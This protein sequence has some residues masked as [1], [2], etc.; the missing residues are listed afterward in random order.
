NSTI[1]DLYR[2]YTDFW[3]EKVARNTPRLDEPRSRKLIQ[4][5]A[6]KMFEKNCWP[7]TDDVDNANRTT[8]LPKIHYSGL[9]SLMP[10]SSEQ[11]HEDATRNVNTTDL[12][13]LAKDLVDAEAQISAS[14]EE[15]VLTKSFLVRDDF[16]NYFFAH[17]SFLEYFVA[18]QLFSDMKEG[19]KEGF[20]KCFLSPEI[21]DF[22]VCLK[23]NPTT[24]LSWIAESRGE[25]SHLHTNLLT[26]LNKTGNNLRGQNFSRLYL[27]GADLGGAD[28][29]NC[30]FTASTL[31]K[32]D[33]RDCRLTNTDF[34]DASFRNL[35][36]GV[37][38][39]A[40]GVAF[41]PNGKF[42][43]SGGGNNAVILL[44]KDREKWLS[45]E[46]LGH[47]DSITNVAFSSDNRFLASS[48]FDQ[49]AIVWKLNGEKHCRLPRHK[50]TVYDVEFTPN[51]NYLF[52]ASKEEI[53]LWRIDDHE[54]RQMIANELSTFTEHSAQV[55]K[56]AVSANG[57]YLASAS[58]D[59]TLGVWEIKESANGIT[60]KLRGRCKG[61]QSLVNGVSFSPDA[62]FVASA[63]N[64]GTIRIWSTDDLRQ[65][66]V[67]QQHAG[68]VWDVAY[69]N[70]GRYLVS[71]SLDKLVKV[72]DLRTEEV[73]TLEG[74][75]KNI[76]SVCFSPDDELVVSGSLDSTV[77]IWD[78]K[79][80]RCVQTFDMG[81]SVVQSFNCTGMK[82]SPKSGLSPFQEIF[83]TEFG[84]RMLPDRSTDSHG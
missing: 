84:A 48:S 49:T 78:W 20:E 24:M 9:R 32:V 16:G 1:C 65:V 73:V 3:L 58:F 43:A 23:P 4:L 72:W 41:S 38:S 26:L 10:T 17:K 54:S 31:I 7:A 60:L 30:D 14:E 71:G 28:L 42:I 50:S 5:L 61:H 36:M 74:H 34:T 66:K 37:R 56:L 62:R 47:Q 19:H 29:E 44:R 67:F 68:I 33:V 75:S 57:E 25:K 79:N 82:F 39:P 46:R 83:L 76:W 52:T 64:D 77:K 27:N 15:E 63:S 2:V 51:G 8:E 53:N 22:L 6:W 40:K 12:E 59:M 80:N 45:K 35:M 81:R 55:Y 70:S 21:V 11:P 18:Q 13:T 69:S